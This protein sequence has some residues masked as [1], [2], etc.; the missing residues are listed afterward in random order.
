[1]KQA[2][3]TPPPVLDHQDDDGAFFVRIL[4]N[5]PCPDIVKTAADTS[6]AQPYEQDYA[7]AVNTPS[8]PLF[9]YPIVDAG[10]AVVS[11]IYFEKTA[12]ALP[13]GLRQEAATRLCEALVSVGLQPT[14]A[15]TQLASAEKTASA[16]DLYEAR[17]QEMRARPTNVVD[18]FLSRAPAQRRELALMM[19]TAGQQLPDD[20]ACYGA[21]AFGSDLQFA[22]NLRVQLTSADHRANFDDLLKVAYA[23][24]PAEIVEVLADFDLATGL[25]RFYDTKLPD[26]YRSVYGTTLE[27]AAM[28]KVASISIGGRDYSSNVVAEFARIH[29]ADINGTF[30]PGVGEQLASSP[31]EVLSSLPDPHRRAIATMIDAAH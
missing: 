25:T 2:N 3:F 7:L 22:C 5:G 19:K 8:G 1:M 24:S 31:V 11:A 14:E 6:L 16:P 30:G 26:P 15:L 20:V 21:E 9:K 13:E 12:S 4:G 23:H 27:K 10:N 29:A 28:R 17:Y 18:E